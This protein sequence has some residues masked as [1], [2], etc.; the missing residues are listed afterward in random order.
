MQQEA[1]KIKN[2]V[3]KG[4]VMHLATLHKL[5]RRVLTEEEKAAVPNYVVSSLMRT[6]EESTD[7]VRH[8]PPPTPAG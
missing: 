4:E 8:P 5:K 6:A 2:Q 1:R 3:A 7:K